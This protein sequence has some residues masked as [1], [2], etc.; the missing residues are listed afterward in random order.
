MGRSSAHTDERVVVADQLTRLHFTSQQDRAS[1]LDEAAIAT[2][3]PFLRVL[4]FTDGT[5]SRTLEAH[6][7]SHVTVEPVDQTTTTG[8]GTTARYLEVPETM[9]CIRRRVTMHIADTP[10]VAVW[11]ESHLIPPR[12]PAD[13]VGVLGDTSQGIG[14]SLQR[15]KLESYRE[16]L[17]FGFD[18]P[19]R[20]G[21]EERPQAPPT[22]TRL[23]RIITQGLP[24]LLIRETFALEQHS[25][26]YCLVGSAARASVP[27]S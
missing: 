15:M 16:L 25:G 20:W 18:T 21:N 9:E 23:Y 27:A 26:V 2:L 8:S 7:L 19:P 13:F 24:T 4:L 1:G 14:G 6:T 17:L 5:V 3:D 12:L 11:A 10:L 22:L